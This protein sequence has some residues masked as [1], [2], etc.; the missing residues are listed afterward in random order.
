MKTIC[1]WCK[2]D[3]GDKPG[4]DHQVSHGICKDCYKKQLE[5]LKPEDS[6]LHAIFLKKD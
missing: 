5:Q 6:L 3:L 2:I 1:A 4:P